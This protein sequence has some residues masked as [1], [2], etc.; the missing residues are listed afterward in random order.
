MKKSL[1]TLFIVVLGLLAIYSAAQFVD[2]T[3]LVTRLHGG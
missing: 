2:V 1:C 3:E